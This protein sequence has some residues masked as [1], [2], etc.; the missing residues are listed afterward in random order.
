MKTISKI[1]IHPFFYFFTFICIFNGLFKDYI[2]ITFI[3]LF[4]ELGHVLVSIYY[5]WNIKKIVLLP[6][7]SLT[8]FNNLINTKLKE[9]FLV[10]IA[11]PLFQ[12]LLFLIKIPKFTYYNKMLLIFNLLPVIPLDGSKIMNIILNKLTTFKNSELISI[13]ISFIMIFYLFMGS[14]SLVSILVILLLLK[15]IVEKCY[16]YKYLFYKFLL[17]RYIYKISFKRVKKIKKITKMKR[18][19]S[20]L[21]Y[22]NKKYYSE[23]EIL[24]KMFD[25]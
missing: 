20:H 19:Y 5:K 22:H 18:D 13:I 23:R 12:I 7:G 24:R 16:L 2:Y 17:E 14:N 3:V 11:G 21:F 25:K 15:K 4:H 9:E 10:T 8:I 1:T 6:F